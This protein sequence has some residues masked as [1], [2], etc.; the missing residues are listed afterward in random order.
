MRCNR[1]IKLTNTAKT[2]YNVVSQLKSSE[3]WSTTLTRETITI[4]KN[5]I[6]LLPESDRKK[7]S[8]MSTSAAVIKTPPKSGNRGNNLK[9]PVSLAVTL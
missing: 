5:S 9:Q 7:T 8:T 6:P 1:I 3:V 4:S 2:W